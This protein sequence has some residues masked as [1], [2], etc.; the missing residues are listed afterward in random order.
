MRFLKYL[1]YL[2][3]ILI[4]LAISGFAFY[5]WREASNALEM[6]RL[7]N[8][9]LQ[10]ANLDLGRAHTQ[11]AN[12]EKIHKTTID[13]I[14]ASWKA[15]I[16]RR[17]ALI[18]LYAELEA[19]Y[20][21]EK[22]KEKIVVKIVYRDTTEELPVGKIFLKKDDGTLFPLDSMYFDYKDFRLDATGDV[23]KQ[24]FSYK[25]HQTFRAQFIE[26]TLPS[27]AKNHYAKIWELDDK[28][29]D[30]EELKLSKFEV[31]SSEKLANSMQWW[32]PHVD[33]GVGYG[34][35]TKI[36]GLL[37]ADLGFSL[38]GDGKNGFSMTFSPAQYNIGGPL[39][40]VSNIW[41]MPYGGWDTGTSALHFGLGLG[42]VF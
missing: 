35:T 24:E 15:E 31:T 39:P 12:E 2:P 14:D 16:K 21:A 1:K 8:T 26:T 19:R 5:Q 32:A 3:V 27:G 25:L 41:L 22:K 34:L 9:E 10:Q 20:E 29:K 18:G 17:E 42:V 38:S 36:V 23:I 37:N 11:L 28:G 13:K 40:L 30:V 7:T 33:I 4:F 6:L